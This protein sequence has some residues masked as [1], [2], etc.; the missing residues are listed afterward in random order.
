MQERHERGNDMAVRAHDETA[1]AHIE[2]PHR[3]LHLERAKP[4]HEVDPENAAAGDR[5]ERAAQ[6]RGD[7][8]QH[9]QQSHW[10]SDPWGPSRGAP[11]VRA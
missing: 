11:H 1:G 8:H 6:E 10:M 5:V 4:V 9:R 3:V 2:G 7:Q